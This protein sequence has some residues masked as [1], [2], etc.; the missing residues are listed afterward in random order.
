MTERII[1]AGDFNEYYE[2]KLLRRVNTDTITLNSNSNDIPLYLKQI[3]D[4]CCGPTI[5]DITKDNL[6]KEGSTKPFDLVYDSN[7]WK[8]TMSIL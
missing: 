7:L 8:A 3:K 2:E 6:A 1:I 4:T 5:L